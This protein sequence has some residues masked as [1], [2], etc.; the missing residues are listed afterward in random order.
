MLPACL[1]DW[2]SPLLSGLTAMRDRR[3]IRSEADPAALTEAIT[4][5]VQGG[6]LLAKTYRTSRPLARALG[7]GHRP[8]VRPVD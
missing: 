7:H 4:A 3:A 1:A 6:L 2:M 8:R 5:A